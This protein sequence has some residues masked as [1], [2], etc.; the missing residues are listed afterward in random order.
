MP[1]IFR[2]FAELPRPTIRSR[3]L[4]HW[5]IP[6]ATYFVTFRL[7]DALPAAVLRELQFAVAGWLRTHRLEDRSQL[8]GLATAQRQEFRRL[9]S[10]REERWL[11][12]GHGS[13]ILRSPAT[14]APVVETLHAFDATRYAL[15]AY[16]IMPNHVHVLFQCLDGWDRSDTVA[17]WKKYSARKINL[18]RGERGAIWQQESFDHIVRDR[19][20]FEKTRRY[21]MNNP[22]KARLRSGEYHLGR[23]SG[24]E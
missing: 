14:R 10:I 7:G 11:D 16:V 15:D 21:I 24:I 3:N 8:H 4:P 13:C 22:V 18:E 19:E 1:A 23:G 2:P 6:G 9:F 17:S 5:D 12:E 20:E